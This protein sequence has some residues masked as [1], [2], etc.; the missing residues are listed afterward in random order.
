MKRLLLIAFVFG[1][2]LPMAAQVTFRND[3]VINGKARKIKNKGITFVTINLSR[4]TSW[5]YLLNGRGG[6]VL[7]IDVEA[8][9]NKKRNYSYSEIAERVYVPISSTLPVSHPVPL[10]LLLPPPKIKMPVFQHRHLF[11]E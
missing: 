8:L 5:N 6:N 2:T 10:F 9:R 3:F 11:S 1:L 4:Y 7:S